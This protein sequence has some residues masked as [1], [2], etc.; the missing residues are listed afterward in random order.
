METKFLESSG[1]QTYSAMIAIKKQ[2]PQVFYKKDGLKNFA[3][4]TGKHLCR[5]LF[6]DKVAGLKPVTLLKR[7]CST[8]VFLGISW[9]FRENFI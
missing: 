8:C 4:F 3:K 7:D 2:P 1:L 9:S 6:F 5:S